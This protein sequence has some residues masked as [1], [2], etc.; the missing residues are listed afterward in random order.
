[1]N[2]KYGRPFTG[3]SVD[4]A[5]AD[6]RLSTTQ[7]EVDMEIICDNGGESTPDSVIFDRKS[8]KRI[9]TTRIC[10]SRLLA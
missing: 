10:V 2:G 8:V 4:A 9:Q 3:Y 1:M 7:W 5:L 6:N